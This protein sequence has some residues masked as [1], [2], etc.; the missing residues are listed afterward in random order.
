MG[1][2]SSERNKQNM[3]AK[4]LF[5]YNEI[6]SIIECEENEEIYKII[7]KFSSALNL[8]EKQAY[9]IYDSKILNK[10]EINLTFNQIVNP[11]D[12]SRKIMDILVIQSIKE[13][14]NEPA[15]VTKD[16]KTDKKV[17]KRKIK[18]ENC[19]VEDIKEIIDEDKPSEID[20]KAGKKKP[21]DIKSETKNNEEKIVGSDLYQNN[22]SLLQASVSL[23]KILTN[24]KIASGFLIK[25]FIDQEDFFCLMTN[26]HVIREDMVTKKINFLFYF[27]NEKKTREI[28]LD[29]N[30]RYIKSFRDINIDAIVIQILPKDNIPSDYFLLPNIDYINNQN[31][32]IN[33][34][35]SV[36]QYPSGKSSY[37]FGKLKSINDNFEFAH[38]ASTLQGS[39]GSPIFLKNTSKVIGIHKMGGTS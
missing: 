25:L 24:K 31:E 1:V 6:T 37:S 22:I 27:D 10:S 15:K 26:E 3:K 4:V 28:K 14:E 20:E 30:E 38:S 11:T 7:N 19:D 32:L 29:T 34:E 35:I 16:K 13:N 12:K 36:L 5:K 8:E 23:C 21:K 2:C 18:N 39:S 17:I 33:E 9:Y